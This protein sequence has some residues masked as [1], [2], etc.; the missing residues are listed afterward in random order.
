MKP[1]NKRVLL[2]VRIKKHLKKVSEEKLIPAKKWES[3]ERVKAEK[4]K[5][6]KEKK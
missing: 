1:L 6:D 3:M 4:A 5:K 2:P